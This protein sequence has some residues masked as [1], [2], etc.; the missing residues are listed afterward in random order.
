MIL[1]TGSR[2]LHLLVGPQRMTSSCMK[3]AI[4]KPRPT[5]TL[6][7]RSAWQDAV[8]SIRT[9]PEKQKR[10]VSM[11]PDRD[12]MQRLHVRVLG[13]T[14]F[15]PAGRHTAGLPSPGKQDA[16]RVIPQTTCNSKKLWIHLT[17]AHPLLVGGRAAT[18]TVF[19]TPQSEADIRTK[20]LYFAVKPTN[21]NGIFKASQGNKGYGEQ[22]LKAT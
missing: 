13:R 4:V 15:G 1:P 22:C 21:R 17:N 2:T 14:V 19:A 10:P 7:G 8:N 6:Y 12:S 11:P 18:R 3:K 9:I 16:D 20:P 5:P